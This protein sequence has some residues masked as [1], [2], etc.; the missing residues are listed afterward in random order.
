VDS[1]FFLLSGLEA[2]EYFLKDFYFHRIW[3]YLFLRKIL[4]GVAKKSGEDEI[5][6]S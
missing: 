5:G 4:P 3:F 6:R 1:W 2:K